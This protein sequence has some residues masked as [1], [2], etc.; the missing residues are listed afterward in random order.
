MTADLREEGAKERGLDQP[1]NS[2]ESH[3]VVSWKATRNGEGS[4]PE[5]N[6]DLFNFLGPKWNGHV[7]R[8]EILSNVFT[9]SDGRF[10]VTAILND[11]Y[12]VEYLTYF[13]A[14]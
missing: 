13:R 7:L 3:D 6:E 14:V 10:L 11:F 9:S 12:I 4:F 2:I 1:L 8:V 5:M